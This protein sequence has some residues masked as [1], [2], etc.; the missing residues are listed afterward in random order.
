ME[1]LLKVNAG[2]SFNPQAPE[3]NALGVNTV[4]F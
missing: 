3:G 2:V 1:F 4:V